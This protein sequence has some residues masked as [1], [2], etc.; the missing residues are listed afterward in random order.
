MKKL[1]HLIMA[2]ALILFLPKIETTAQEQESVVL[3]IQTIDCR[4][5]LKMDDEEREFTLI[6]FHGFK[7]GKTSNVIFNG[8]E[9]LAATNSIM[10]FCIDNPAQSLMK[11]FDEK[12]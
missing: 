8:P 10:D 11:A 4:T 3:D 12:R 2:T 6:F 1:M 9:F 5:M 7:S